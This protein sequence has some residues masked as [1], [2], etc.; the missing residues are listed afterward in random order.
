[1]HAY[2]SGTAY[3]SSSTT[4]HRPRIALIQSRTTG[5]GGFGRP[6]PGPQR[7]FHVTPNFC[8]DFLVNSII[9]HNHDVLSSISPCFSTDFEFLMRLEENNA[10]IYNPKRQLSNRKWLWFW[11]LNKYIAPAQTGSQ[12]PYFARH[13]PNLKN[14]MVTLYSVGDAH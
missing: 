6:V 5:A 4:D 14:A 3:G 11:N 9:D 1:M 2:A 13:T 7:V 8:D 12:K 10:D